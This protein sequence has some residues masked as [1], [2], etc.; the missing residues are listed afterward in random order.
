MTYNNNHQKNS[1]ECS[2][3]NQIFSRKANAERHNELKH[4]YLTTIND[5]RLQSAKNTI[6]PQLKNPLYRDKIKQFQSHPSKSKQNNNQEEFFSEDV[7]KVMKIFDQFEQPFDELEKLVDE[8]DEY[9]I[10][11]TISNIFL[12]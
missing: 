9:I 5:T 7:L 1:Y 2:I 8:N 6:K 12:N 10:A 3:C 11:N 4:D